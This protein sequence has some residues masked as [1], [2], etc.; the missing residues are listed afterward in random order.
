MRRSQARDA[1]GA[2][3]GID[4]TERK[5]TFKLVRA[6]CRIHDPAVRRQIFELTKAI[7][8]GRGLS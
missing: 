1:T 6:Y 3:N 8:N 4:P 2:R 7:A 5:E